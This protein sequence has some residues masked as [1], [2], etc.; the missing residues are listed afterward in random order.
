MYIAHSPPEGKKFLPP[1]PLSVHLQNV[2][3][4]CADLSS[5]FD[6]E[7]E[8][9]I[10]GENH[11]YG[12]ASD[13]G[14]KRICDN[15]PRVDHSTAG[16][17]RVLEGTK[18]GCLLAACIMGHHG[19]LP[20]LG[21]RLDTVGDS[22]FM[23]RYK[24]WQE[25]LIPRPNA[26]FTPLPIPDLPDRK[27][28]TMFSE[29]MRARMLFS[30]LVDA[31]Y[32]DTEEYMKGEMPR[33]T[34]DPLPVL[35]TRLQAKLKS[36]ENPARD[37]NRWRNEI[38]QA[39]ID[40]AS[41]PRG[42]F[43]LTVPTG[44]AKTISS[45][46]FALN[47]AIEHGMER[48]IYV[49]PYTSII[50]QNAKEYKKIL[51]DI[52]VLEHHSGVQYDSSEDAD[53][54]ELAMALATENW[55]CPVVVTTAVQFFESLY[56]NRPSQCRKLHN[57]ANSVIIFDEAQMLPLNNLEPCVAAMG[58][59]VEQC[60]STIVLCTAT[61]PA[62][63]DLLLKYAK[64][65][66]PTEICPHVEDYFNRF[67]RVTF[68]KMGKIG[69]ASLANLLCEH[70]QVLCIVNSRKAALSIYAHLPAEGSY[71]LST[72][73]NSVHRRA[74]LDEIRERL[75]A[76]LPC[77]VISTSL[78]EAGVDI[79]FPAVFRELA[80]LDSILQAAGRCNREGRWSAEESIVTIFQREASPPRAFEKYIDAAQYALADDADPAAP[81]TMR[82][83]FS[84]LRMLNGS[85]IDK[86]G[87]IEAFEQ[88]LEGCIC[89]F[90]TVAENFHMIEND[91]WTIYI[92]WGE[93]GKQLTK[94]LIEG[95]CTK[96]LYRALG[97]YAVQAY[98]SHYQDLHDVGAILP[99]D[100]MSKAAVLI[101][102]NKYDFCTGLEMKTEGGDCYIV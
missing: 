20:D 39:C 17:I 89:P 13:E 71:H 85:A 77:R 76:G 51:G 45:L 84:F 46:A 81:Q 27:E 21:N 19:G 69:D 63:N 62:L 56:S 78:I 95:E 42:I 93:K 4:K 49:V 1:Q 31:D 74:I 68:R 83:Y 36:W 12:K 15:G 86:S 11:D 100:N 24:K 26:D 7:I 8:G 40:A 41:K 32:L 94:R 99:I 38:T 88:G 5:S 53:E 79:D 50:E 91:T 22:T 97:Q 23:G 101:C 96:D 33:S 80:G 35:W 54:K 59:L 29:A 37:I 102:E 87:V 6:A 52:N 82:K 34:S 64:S 2:G 43:T 92:P 25:G 75:S 60:K 16:A 30:A 57:T 72:L 55:D 73:M 10:I 48:I 9:Q 65:Y 14:Q 18:N 67:R 66:Q 90:R 3:K 61:Q 44:G 47:H 70:K 58:E 28:G 98:S